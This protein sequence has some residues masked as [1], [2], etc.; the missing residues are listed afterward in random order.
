MHPFPY[1]FRVGRPQTIDPPLGIQTVPDGHGRVTKIPFAH[2]VNAPSSVHCISPAVHEPSDDEDDD[3]DEEEEEVSGEQSLRPFLPLFFWHEVVP[4]G[5]D[6]V[7]SDEVVSGAGEV[8]SGVGEVVSGAGEVG[9]GEVLP[10]SKV[11]A[12]LAEISDCNGP[13]PF[14]FP[15]FAG[16]PVG[17]SIVGKSG[18]KLTLVISLIGKGW[19]ELP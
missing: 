7:V 9:A 4:V 13:D 6:E 15:E 14:S 19:V 1:N 12:K 10:E 3:D 2:V 16:S 18:G 8:V 5:V 17:V 11:R